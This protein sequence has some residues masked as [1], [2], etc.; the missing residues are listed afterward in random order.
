AS[1]PL[2]R[3][4]A[5]GRRPRQGLEDR[6]RRAADAL[7]RLPEGDGARTHGGAGGGRQSPL[8]GI[9][10]WVRVSGIGYR[11]QAKRGPRDDDVRRLSP[12]LPRGPRRVLARRGA[13]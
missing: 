12:P 6:L 13:A 7:R 3:E 8:T 2:A 9:G 1:D 4:W 10:H 11:K 5:P